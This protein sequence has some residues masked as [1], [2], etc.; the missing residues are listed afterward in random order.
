MFRPMK[1][2]KEEIIGIL[3]AVDYRSQADLTALIES[4]RAG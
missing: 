1:V 4:G 2:G 3:A